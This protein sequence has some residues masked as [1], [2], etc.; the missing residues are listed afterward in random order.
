MH[1]PTPDQPPPGVS[2]DFG[3]QNT[4]DGARVGDV[5]GR[6]ILKIY[7]IKPREALQVLAQTVERL[8]NAVQPLILDAH[9][10]EALERRDREERDRRVAQVDRIADQ[11]AQLLRDQAQMLRRLDMANRVTILI[12]VVL[13]LAEGV[14]LFLIIR[15]L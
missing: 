10:R 4:I 1:S 11:H 14:F 7:D 15:L 6:D 5:A 2:V 9:A 12:L 13:L 3:R 8:V